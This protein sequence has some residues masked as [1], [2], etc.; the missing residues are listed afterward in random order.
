M[1]C[2]AFMADGQA[3][4]QQTASA[5]PPAAAAYLAG[6]SILAQSA[7]G[8]DQTGTVSPDER[9]TTSRPTTK[10][11]YAKRL[12]RWSRALTWAAVLLLILIFGSAAIAVF[13]RRFKAFLIRPQREPTEYVDAWRL[14]KLPPDSA[15]QSGDS[16]EDE[17]DE[18]EPP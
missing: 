12:A 16:P 8:T 2:S 11:A 18:A 5:T 1:G 14:H 7:A 17:N 15:P 13:S 3:T 4:A 10:P 6:R 9:S